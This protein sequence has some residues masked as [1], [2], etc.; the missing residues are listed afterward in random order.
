MEFNKIFKPLK[1]RFYFFSSFLK[2]I[3]NCVED[4]DAIGR[5]FVKYVNLFEIGFYTIFDLTENLFRFNILLT[6]ETKGHAQN[7]RLAGVV[8]RCILRIALYRENH[9]FLS[10]I[11]EF[12]SI[13]Q[14]KTYLKCVFFNLQERR[15]HMYVVYCQNKPKSEFLVSEYEQFF[16]VRCARKSF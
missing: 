8:V 11:I 10:L 13:L 4:Y 5:A 2:E 6:M 7:S 12:V 15:L 9:F 14:F 1:C 3:E 16:T